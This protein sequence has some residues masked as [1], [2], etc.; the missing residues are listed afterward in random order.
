MLEISIG[1]SNSASPQR[2]ELQLRDF[3]IRQQAAPAIMTNRYNGPA[4]ASDTPRAMTVDR[5]E[6]YV[7]GTSSSGGTSF[8]LWI[9]YGQI[10]RQPALRAASRVLLVQDTV[11][12]GISI[13]S[14]Q[15]HGHSGD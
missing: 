5:P 9:G 14:Q 12:Y 8:V 2:H 4:T 7:T 3:E 1:R 15:R 6:V 11:R 10:C 13:A